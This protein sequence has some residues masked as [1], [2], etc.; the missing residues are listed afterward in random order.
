[1]RAFVMKRVGE[2]GW[3]EKP[4][5]DPGPGDAVVRTT[6]ALVCTSDAHTV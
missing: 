1:M 3:A 4:V 5:P 2:V 6:A